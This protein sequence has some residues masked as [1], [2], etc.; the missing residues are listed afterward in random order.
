M[1][2]DYVYALD[3]FRY[4]DDAGIGV[5]V[6]LCQ[7]ADLSNPQTCAQADVY[8]EIHECE[9]LLDIIHYDFLMVYAQYLYFGAFC[10]CREFYIH[11]TMWHISQF[12]GISEYHPQ[13]NKNVF[14]R[15]AAKSLLQLGEDE[16]LNEGF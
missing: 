6:I 12:Y 13:Y 11:L 14:D 15:F 3:S 10:L 9:M 7:G 5:N 2:V 1:A 16:I 4:V 8:A